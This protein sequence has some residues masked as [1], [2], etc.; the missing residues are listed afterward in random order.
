V[1]GARLPYRIEGHGQTCLILGSVAYYS[2]VFSQAL[3]EHL[4]LVFVDLRHFAPSD[5]AFRPDQISI[6]TFADD[7]E[8]VRET[9]ALG[10]VVVI[11]HSLHATFALEHARRYPEHVSGVVVI[12]AVPNSS[13]YDAAY[14]QLR[15]EAPERQ[16]RLARKQVEL[17]PELAASLSPHEFFVREYVARGPIHWYDPAYDG[18]W[19]WDD[20]Q[21]NMPVVER[22]YAILDPFDLA[23]GPGAI[24]VP[25]LIAHGR[26]DYGAPYTLWERHRHKLPRHTFALF[27]KSGHTPP[28]EEPERFDRTL[29]AWLGR[30]ERS[31]D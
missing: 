15:E 28:L 25:V 8:R 23:Q 29:L 1:E 12:G 2:R 9:L 5:P 19:L 22:I 26:Y 21:L 24:N 6:D 7:I 18:S 27:E 17:T 11:G 16:A 30:L 20:T 31:R 10:S 13:D 14:E 3:R 4:R